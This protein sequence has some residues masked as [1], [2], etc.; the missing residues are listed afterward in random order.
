MAELTII[1]GPAVDPT[2]SNTTSGPHSS[3]L[4]NKAD[5]RVDSDNDRTTGVGSSN[6]T[7]T[8]SSTTSGPH[9][10]DAANKVDPRVDSDLDGSRTMGGNKTYQ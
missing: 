4:A 7:G 10:S 5:L 2:S 9:S 3:D 1:P 6:I 8:S